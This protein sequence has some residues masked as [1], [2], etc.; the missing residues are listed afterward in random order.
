MV[1][2]PLEHKENKQ[3]PHRKT[4]SLESNP[5]PSCYEA[6][7]LTTEPPCFYFSLC[8]NSCVMF[9]PSYHSYYF[10]AHILFF[11]TQCTLKHMYSYPPYIHIVYVSGDHLSILNW[12]ELITHFLEKHVKKTVKQQVKIQHV[13]FPP[14]LYRLP[15]FKDI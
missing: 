9:I 10:L 5:G 8:V 4:H 13:T 11:K 15:S 7:V 2:N 14:H 3:T 12:E 6:T 1:G